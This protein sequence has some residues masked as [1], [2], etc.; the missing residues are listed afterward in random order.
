MV[1]TS[2]WPPLASFMHNGTDALS[3]TRVARY[4]TS[5]VANANST[6]NCL[7][8]FWKNDVLRKERVKVLKSLK[9]CLKCT[10]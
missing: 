1:V 5:T 6:L 9:N 2:I 7:I 4:W 10:C 3:R 8:F